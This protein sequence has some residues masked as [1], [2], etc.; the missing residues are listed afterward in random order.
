MDHSVRHTGKMFVVRYDD[1]GLS[2]FFA[3]VEKEAVKFFLIMR[4]KISG[5]FIG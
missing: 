3:K 2:E 4:I 1:K 5:R